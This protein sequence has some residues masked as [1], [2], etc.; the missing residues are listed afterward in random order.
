[1]PVTEDQNLSQLDRG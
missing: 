1:M